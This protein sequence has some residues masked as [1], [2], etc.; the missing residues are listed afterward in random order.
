MTRV[1]AGLV[2]A[3]SIAMLAF[4][5][6][7]IEYF[8]AVV[9]VPIALSPF[10]LVGALLIARVP[11][12]AVGWLLGGS[13]V[14][15]GLTIAGGPYGWLAL[16]RDPGHLPGGE[17]AAALWTNGFAPGLGL[18]A[19]MLLFFPSGHG[20]GGRW[21]WLERVVV[22]LVVL[23]TLVDFLKD[24]PVAVGP[25]HRRPTPRCSSPIRSRSMGRLV[26]S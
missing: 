3:V 15:F 19:L 2:V 16:V 13:G 14:V 21:A 24:V 9:F 17:A 8:G 12:N 4:C 18:A 22:A 20:L 25:P 26:S 7:S 10:A 5:L 11:R 23:I 6:L 1:V